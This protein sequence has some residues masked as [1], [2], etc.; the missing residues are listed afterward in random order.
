MRSVFL[1]ILLL[2][3]LVSTQPVDACPAGRAQCSSYCC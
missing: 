2:L 3:G 1:A